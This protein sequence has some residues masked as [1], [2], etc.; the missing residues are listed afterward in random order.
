VIPGGLAFCTVVAKN[1]LARAR[2]LVDSVRRHHPE[3]GVYVLFVD[4]PDGRFEPER[5]PFTP[6]ALA[7]LDLPRPPEF[8]FRYGVVELCTAVRPYLLRL[9]FRRGHSHLVYLDPD[10]RVYAPLDA[11]LGAL[12]RCNVL[13]TPHLLAPLD[14]P[15]PGERGI[16]LSGAYNMGFLGL[17]R[18]PAAD[19]LLAWLSDRLE[20]ECLNDPANGLFVDQRWMDLAPGL[21][22]G[23]HVLRDAGYNVGHWN[24]GQ[25][26]LSGT[27]DAPRAGGRPLVLFHFSGFHPDRPDRLSRYD[28]APRT[29]EPLAA[30]LSRYR[31][32]LLAAGH[33]TSSAWAYSHGTF[34]DGHPVGAEMRALFREQPPGRFPDPFRVDGGDTFLRWAVSERDRRDAKVAAAPAPPGAATVRID[35][36]APIAQ[37]ILAVRDDV[38]RAYETADGRLDWRGLRTWL[39][40]DGMR[41]FDLKPEWCADWAGEAGAALPRAFAF[42][43]GRPD[44]QRR[45]PM[46]FV[47]EHDAGAF[48][49]WLEA[50]AA[51]AGLA[52]GEVA[53]LRGVVESAPVARIREIHGRRADVRAAYPAAM[54]WPPDPGFLEWLSY[55]GK[56]EHDLPADWA[57]WFA[58]SQAQH[59][60]LRVH[61]AHAARADWREAHPR[62]LDALGRPPF[63]AWLKAA[64][65]PE[66]GPHPDAITHLCA[67]GAPT[68]LEELR[69]LHAADPE[70]AGR[71][72]GAFRE[73]PDTARLLSALRA[74]A[75][76]LEPGWV[77]S[78]EREMHALGLLGHGV[79]LVLPDAGRPG[80]EALARATARALQAAAYPFAE[81]G[82]DAA[83]P[84]A[85]VHVD[86]AGAS[87]GPAPRAGGCRIAYC[88]WE[89]EEWPASTLGTLASFDEV[90]TWSRH[91]AAALAGAVPVPVQTVWPAVEAGPRR[92]PRGG[93]RECTF[94][95]VYDRDCRTDRVNPAAPIR[96]FRDAFRPDDPVRLLIHAVGGGSTRD[97]LRGLEDVAQGLRVV[98]QQGE[99]AAV[100]DLL[101]TCDAYVSLH[102]AEGFGLQMAEAMA[103]GIPVIATYHSGNVDYMTPWGSFPVPYALVEVPGGPGRPR[104]GGVWAEADA[105]AA[106]HL[107]R[108]VY[109]RP[110]EA[111]AVGG[112]GREDV[113][114]LLAPDACGRRM[115]ERFRT[116]RRMGRAGPA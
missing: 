93:G 36:L 90:W 86:S 91:A 55:S 74:K 8:R 34:S 67:P 64:A 6:V 15:P 81:A 84:F 46:A 114:R 113:G 69:G 96:A 101:G 32:E 112:R 4:D 104:E 71:F 61:Q 89:P 47:E 65:A 44:L 5:E 1:Y 63:L 14:G 108:G 79:S 30:L 100:P 87:N 73:M 94:L 18:G 72:P 110:E 50:H 48:L 3:A 24:I 43:D 23:V 57:P 45:F 21:V 42:Y 106:A 19:E 115:Q 28:D 98:I 22:D 35:D 62:G 25:R 16:L 77:D 95:F 31:E 70:L 37:R 109:E 40:N 105:G 107:M 26:P 52:A 54:G 9:L 97:D 59:V 78:V 10:T 80:A 7:E 53:R 60:C 49:A 2:V 103:R 12:E 20:R 41:E 29:E 38:R 102:R 17:R 68:P 116:L 99:R 76:E 56:R 92:A 111:A 27:V 83:L 66:L 33:E 85:L 58:R 51:E 39:E 13:L 88:A 75:A 11:A 82:D